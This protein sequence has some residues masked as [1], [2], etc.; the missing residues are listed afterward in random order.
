MSGT[1]PGVPSG[2]RDFLPETMARRKFIINILESNFRKYGLLPLETPAMENLSTLT[3]KYGE[4]GD[5][6]IYKVLNSGDFLAKTET[7]H[8]T[9]SQQ[10]LPKI[11]DKGLRYDLTV[12]F[13]RVVATHRHALGFPFKR[14]QIQN[15]WRA[16]RPQKGRYREFWQCDADIIG[17]DSLVSEAELVCLY[18]ESLSMLGLQNFTILINNRKILTGLAEICGVPDQLTALCTAI[19][20]LD[21]TSIEDVLQDLRK[22]GFSESIIQKTN[23]YLNLTLSSPEDSLAA[24]TTFFAGIK[25][26]EKGISELRELL[27]FHSYLQHFNAEIKIDFTL[28]RGLNYYTGAIFEVKENNTSI[29]SIGGGGRY[30][31]LTGMFGFPGV[32]GIGISF[33]LDRIYDVLENLNLLSE[34][35]ASPT[36][37]LFAHFGDKTLE[38]GLQCLNKIRAAGIAAELYPGTDKIGKQITYA[39]KKGIPFVAVCG[40][41][42]MAEQKVQVKYLT[43]GTQEAITLEILIER[44]K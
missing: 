22:T 42:E 9:S 32:S 17:S 13:A 18:D 27:K 23:D 19:D 36:K 30:D 35:K 16:D 1:T 3:G 44:L 38:Y 25:V 2:M 40:E 6:L 14:Y 37:V 28:A 39:D 31:N 43:S 5:R 34:V 10:L 12:P 15:V 7:E 26:A 8:F 4:E 29:G 21:K 20:K 33:G 24:A 11:S 41:S